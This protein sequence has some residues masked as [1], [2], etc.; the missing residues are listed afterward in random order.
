MKGAARLNG[1]FD[2]VKLAKIADAIGFKSART[3]MEFSRLNG[4][5]DMDSGDLQASDL[6]GPFRLMT[7]SKDIV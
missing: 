7:R 3:D 5:L 2:N 4:D 1:E 6:I